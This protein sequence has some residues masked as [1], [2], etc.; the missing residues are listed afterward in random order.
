MT[1]KNKERLLAVILK[2]FK[3]DGAVSFFSLTFRDD[4]LEIVS[5]HERHTLTPNA[6]FLFEMP[7]DVTEIDM[8]Q[9]A[10]FLDHNVV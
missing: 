3:P 5:Q 8:K 4:V 2:G 6:E 10:V 7:E 1:S 9:L